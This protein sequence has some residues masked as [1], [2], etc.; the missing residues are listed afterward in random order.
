MV[1]HDPRKPL[2]R[3]RPGRAGTTKRDETGGAVELGASPLRTASVLPPVHLEPRDEDTCRTHGTLR[4][5]RI[6]GSAS[7]QSEGDRNARGECEDTGEKC[8]KKRRIKLDWRRNVAR[9]RSRQSPGRA[10]RGP[11]H[12]KEAEIAGDCG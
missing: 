9:R 6:P 7:G 8:G 10:G 11:D 3:K 1:K 4:R 2:E 12:C 5:V